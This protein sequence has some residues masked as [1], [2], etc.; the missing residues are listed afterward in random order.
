MP[1]SFTCTCGKTYRVRDELAGKTVQCKE[2]YAAVRVPSP[3]DDPEDPFNEPTTAYG[4]NGVN[5]AA[6]HAPPMPPQPP[7]YA[8]PPMYSAPPTYAAPPSMLERVMEGSVVDTGAY[9]SNTAGASVDLGKYFT[10][11]PQGPIVATGAIIIGVIGGLLAH[12]AAFGV[13]AVGLWLVIQEI[14][15]VR[16]KFRTGDLN[17]AI[18][19]AAKPWRVAVVADMSTGGSGSRWAVLV[20]PLPM[21]RMTGGPPQVGMPLA[22]VCHYVG[23]GSADAWINLDPTIVQLAITSR[24]ECDRILRRIPRRDWQNMDRVLRQLPSQA[25]GLYKL[26]LGGANAYATGTKKVALMVVIA[27]MAIVPVIAIVANINKKNTASTG[28]DPPLAAA[29][30]DPTPPA[31]PPPPPSPYPTKAPVARPPAPP[32]GQASSPAPSPS[33]AL[34]AAK[35]AHHNFTLWQD[36]DYKCGNAWRP[37]KIVHIDGDRISVFPND[38]A[39]GERRR[40]TLAPSDIR[41]RSS[42]PAPPTAST[43]ASPST[44]APSSPSADASY[45]VGDAVEI[46]WGAK[47]W[48]GRIKEIR[49]DK[50]FVGYDGWSD[51]HDEAVEPSRLRRK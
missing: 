14:V 15:K 31:S 21:G 9:A 49:G 3:Q 34:P 40:M 11:Y 28:S 37:G 36:I 20:V 18:I 1:I 26:W 10:S 46:E 12:P 19:I 8:A 7:L 24:T 6:L 2:C 5:P 42:D 22:A 16:A 35:T 43:P 47:W 33:P 27:M 45:K 30:A 25:P 32:T 29:P 50:Y 39:L 13:A 4:V 17:P 44:P 23:D 51:V 48:P 41:A 38:G